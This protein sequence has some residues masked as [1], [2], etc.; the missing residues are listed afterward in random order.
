MKVRTGETALFSKASPLVGLRDSLAI[1]ADRV[2][3]LEA[4]EAKLKDQ[5]VAARTVV[6]D[7][8]KHRQQ[9]ESRGKKA[10]VAAF[11]AG[12]LAF[13]AG[14]WNLGLGVALGFTAA[15]AM[16]VA[17]RDIY[18][19]NSHSWKDK[20]ALAAVEANSLENDIWNVSRK[21]GIEEKECEALRN[22]VD[23]LTQAEL[24]SEATA[25]RLQVSEIEFKEE[26]LEIGDFYVPVA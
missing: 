17:A 13:V 7:L 9:A 4:T 20:R 5:Y 1:S 23:Q 25:R 14:R 26:A 6:D 19:L 18:V 16:V 24:R 15:A 8:S 12:T 11:G 2:A 21:L 10:Y 22:Q 3:E